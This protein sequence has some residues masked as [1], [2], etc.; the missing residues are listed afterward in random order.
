[1]LEA[2]AHVMERERLDWRDGSRKRRYV[3]LFPI[4]CACFAVNILNKN[5]YACT[6]YLN[7]ILE[8]MALGIARETKS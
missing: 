3:A 4:F 2:W 1:M 5:A 7:L 8:Q 6:R